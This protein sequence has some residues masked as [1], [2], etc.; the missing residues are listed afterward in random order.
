MKSDL[1]GHRF[2]KLI[3]LWQAGR[4]KHNKALWSCQC[5]CGSISVATTGKLRVAS[6]PRSCMSCSKVTH[7]HTKGHRPSRTYKTWESMKRRCLNPKADKYP[8]YG[9]RGIA[10]CP[11]WQNSFETF[12]R[13]MGVRPVGMTIDRIDS[14]GD[15]KASNCRWATPTQQNRNRSFF[16]LVA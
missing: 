13:A 2:G 15:Y 16:K 10:V 12:L 5:D 11:E 14:N 1:I 4:N 7:G 8:L 6:G 3:V 9:G